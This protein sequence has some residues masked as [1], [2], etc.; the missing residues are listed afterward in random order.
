MQYLWGNKFK[1]LIKTNG[2]LPI[3]KIDGFKRVAAFHVLETPPKYFDE[4][5][6]VAQ[7]C[8]WEAKQKYCIEHNI[9]Y[10]FI[11]RNTYQFDRPHMHIEKQAF[12]A[13]SG[14]LHACDGEP[15]WD[16][17]P[18][19]Q[20]KPGIPG[21][22]GWIKPDVTQLPMVKCYGCKSVMDFELFMDGVWKNN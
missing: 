22:P 6:I 9:P 12:L 4:Y 15:K 16:K 18:Y 10:K 14:S 3:P 8:D 21:D 1:G 11:G 20:I 7:T 19:M 13:P 17:G 5:L 2:L